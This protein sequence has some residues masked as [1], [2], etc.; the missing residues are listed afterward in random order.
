MRAPHSRDKNSLF[1]AFL[2][3]P[4]WEGKVTPE[5]SH[6][7][8]G[9]SPRP[10]K[11]KLWGMNRFVPWN[12]STASPLTPRDV[13]ELLPW[14]HGAHPLHGGT[15]SSGRAVPHRRGESRFAGRQQQSKYSVT[16]WQGKQISFSP[17]FLPPQQ[18]PQVVCLPW[19]AWAE[20]RKTQTQNLAAKG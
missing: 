17:G 12:G 9:E 11:E 3:L 15:S 13:L 18:H 2:S 6:P 10:A 19:A 14:Q 1:Q 4:G 8:P 20:F 16:L 7:P 5:P